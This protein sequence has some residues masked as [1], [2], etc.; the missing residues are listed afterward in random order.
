MLYRAR[1]NLQAIIWD[2]LTLCELSILFAGNTP[3]YWIH[4]YHNILIY[5]VDAPAC[6]PF[7]SVG[8]AIINIHQN[9]YHYFSYSSSRPPP[10]TY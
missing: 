10:Q 9:I 4:T 6:F 8:T 5:I 3:R 1:G 7:H 2:C